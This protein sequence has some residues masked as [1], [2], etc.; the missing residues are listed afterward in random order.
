MKHRNKA[1]IFQSL[2]L[3]LLLGILAGAVGGLAV[4]VV[5][6]RPSTAAPTTAKGN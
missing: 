2:P 5:T 3:L 6:S 4:G 1:S